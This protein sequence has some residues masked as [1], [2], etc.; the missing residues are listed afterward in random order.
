METFPAT[1]IQGARQVGK[2][3]FAAQL[4]SGTRAR[5]VTLDDE[6]TRL[7]ARAEPVAFVEQGGAGTLVIDELQRAPE[8]LLAIKASIDRDRRPGR[9]V[10]TGSSNLLKLSRTPDSLAGRAVTV[11]LRPLSVGEAQGR[12]DDIISSLR[13][14]ADPADFST[15]NARQESIR[16]VACGGYPEARRLSERMRN[17]WFDG[18]VERLLDRDVKDIAPRVDSGR[19]GSVLRLLAANQSGELVKARI[20]RDVDVPETSITAYVDLLQT[21]YLTSMLRPWTPNL[22]SREAARPK[23]IVSDSGLAARLTRTPERQLEP[24]GNPFLG[25]ALEGFVVAELMKQRTWSSEEYELF[26]FRDR[27]GAEVDIVVELA[28]GSVIGFE[29]KASSTLKAEHLSGLRLLRDKLGERFLGGYVLNTAEAGASMGDRLW[30]L[31]IPA[32]WL[33]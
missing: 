3:T 33:I 2:S 14:G 22:T 8:L 27:N 24:L 19:I 17:V 25:A 26:H 1:V 5:I 7:A 4:V 6:S 13:R 32:L 28:D 29:V 23:T 12:R 15:T 18:Y 20:A 11:E 21:M 10:L 31:P 16:L 30:A 9:F